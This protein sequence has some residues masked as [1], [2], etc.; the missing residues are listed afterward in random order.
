V[1]GV[2][3]AAGQ[4]R[5]LVG[6]DVGPQAGAGKGGRHGCDVV[7]ESVG[8]DDQGRGLQ[9]RGAHRY[10]SSINVTGPSLTSSTCIS[11]RKRPVSTL[12]PS[13]L[14]ALTNSETS[15]SAS[16]GRAA[17]IHDGRRPRLVSP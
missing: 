13:S 12:P 17:A 10:N 3:L 2:G 1:A 14:S 6:L 4:R 15:G 16:S 7:V 11:A 9:F 8:V 5:A